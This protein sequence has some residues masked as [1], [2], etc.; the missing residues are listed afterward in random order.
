MEEMTMFSCCKKLK[1]CT[2]K[3]CHK[4]LDNP[5]L[6]VE[7]CKNCKKILTSRNDVCLECEVKNAKK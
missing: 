1:T 5:F 7:E 3:D 2:K 6:Y 4:R